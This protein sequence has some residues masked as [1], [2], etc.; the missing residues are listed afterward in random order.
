MID[1][2]ASRKRSLRGLGL[3]TGW[4]ADDFFTDSARIE[5]ADTLYQEKFGRRLP[6]RVASQLRDDEDI[7]DRS[8]ISAFVMNRPPTSRDIDAGEILEERREAEQERRE[9]LEEQG[10]SDLPE[11]DLKSDGSEN[12]LPAWALPAVGG[13]LVL[14]V[15]AAVLMKKKGSKK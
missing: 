10:L 14:G 15:A 11:L 4:P 9:R 1:S 7:C 2:V 3:C 8:E 12:K 6:E 13:I 5:Y